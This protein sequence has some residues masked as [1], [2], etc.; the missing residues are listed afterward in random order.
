[1]S[2]CFFFRNAKLRKKSG[3]GML[4]MILFCRLGF[5]L[6]VDGDAEDGA[7]SRDGVFEGDVS[8][9]VVLYDASCE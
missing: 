1:M 2:K 9:V 5:L 3:I 4:W 6:C 8:F 7:L